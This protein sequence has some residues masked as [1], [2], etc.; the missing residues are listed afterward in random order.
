MTITHDFATIHSCDDTAGITVVGDGAI[1]VNSQLYKEGTGALNIYKPYTTTTLFGIE[2]PIPATSFRDKLFAFWLYVKSSALSKLSKIRLIF[3]DSSGNYGYRDVSPSILNPDGWKSIV[4][5]IPYR[6]QGG[7]YLTDPPFGDLNYYTSTYPDVTTIVKVRIEFYTNNAS[8][9]V[10][11]GDLV[12][13]WIKLGRSII[14]LEGVVGNLFTKVAQYDKQNALGVIDY[15][16]GSVLVKGAQ[17]VIG[18]GVS[19]YTCSSLG[20]SVAIAAPQESLVYIY[21]RKYSK[22][23]IGQQVSG[24][25]GKNG[26]VFNVYG[27]PYYGYLIR[28]EDPTYSYLEVWQG[29]FNFYNVRGA[30]NGNFVYSINAKVYNAE[31]TNAYIGAIY[32]ATYELYNV[33]TVSGEEGIWGGTCVDLEEYKSF[34]ELA[35]I[36]FESNQVATV[37]KLTARSNTYLVRLYSFYGNATLVDVTADSFDRYWTGTA[38]LNTGTVN[39]AFTFSPRF[40]DPLGNPLAGCR[41]RLIDAF[42]NVVYDNYTDANGVAPSQVIIVK[43]WTGK[44]ST[45]VN[46]DT[47][48]SYNPFTLEVYKDSY[49]VFSAKVTIMAPFTQDIAVS[50]SFMSECYTNKSYYGLNENAIITAEFRDLSGLGITGLSVTAEITKP[51]GTTTAISLSEKGGG[52]YEGTFTGTDQIGT[53]LVEASTSIYGNTVKAKASFTVGNL[54]K[55]L[56]E[57]RRLIF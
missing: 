39:L 5:M 50:F 31:F 20:E 38:S 10:G 42:G 43:K 28:G 34:G 44:A 37:K 22:L 15:M 35:P 51:D 26:S 8:D 21:V 47:E 55:L 33:V 14:V 36:A 52:A 30:F 1:S 19:G 49:K 13:D 4:Y 24:K 27:Y 9:T 29:E 32:R 11:E 18:D 57:I 7:V 53:Y 6:S 40:L 41:V 25:I 12:V 16:D 3:Y 48:T 54:E 2:I 17:I 56:A 23:A 45:G 46:A